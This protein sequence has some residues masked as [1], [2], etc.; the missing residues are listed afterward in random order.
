MAAGQRLRSDAGSSTTELV[1][2]MPVVLLLVL[3]GV[4]AGM[5]YHAGHVIEAAAQEALESAQGE[6]GSAQ[7]GLD[8][9]TA[10]LAEAGG[11]RNP[12]VEVTRDA[13]EVRVLVQAE[14]PNV[15][16][17]AVWHV[18]ASV[19]GPVERFVAEVDR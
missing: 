12:D 1:L 16:P 4:H 19:A 8:S 18:T 10:F 5:Y 6:Q 9:A 14:A 3:V 13:A 15:L 2:M 7:D 17:F 11:I